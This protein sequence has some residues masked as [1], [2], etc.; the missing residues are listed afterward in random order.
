MGYRG[1]FR[2]S[3]LMIRALREHWPEYCIEAV[4]LGAFM[5]SAGLLTALLEYPNSPVR[6]AMPNDF[7]RL[8]LNGLAMGLT[9]IAIIYSP[10]GARSGAHMNPAVTWTF[11]RLG[12]VKAWDALFYP[13][14]QTLGGIA[15]VLLVRLIL[16]QIFTDAPVRC[17]VTVPGKTG[18]TAAFIAEMAIA[19]GM[20]LMVLFMTNT[21]KL[22]HYTGLFGGTLVFLYIT[23]EAPLSGMSINPARTVASALPSGVWTSVWIYFVAPISGMLL[24]VEI[25]KSMR[26]G[27][28]VA[29]AKWNHDMRHRCI[30]C[31]HP[32]TQRQE[33]PPST[34]RARKPHTTMSNKT[35]DSLQLL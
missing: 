14:F 26:T 7:M 21:P 4:C 19:C 34:T 6:Q 3:V 22:A 11:F 18:V 13:V 24:A 30:F 32:G 25:Y 29:C 2:D 9:A 33:K 8:A 5:I 15:G 10:W 35:R 28:R 23:F 20:M 1:S 16:G 17:V 31:G 27:A 12:K